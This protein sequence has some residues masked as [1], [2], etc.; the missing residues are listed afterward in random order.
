MSPM[1]SG[2]LT[3]F[4]S[5]VHRVF[6]FSTSPSALFLAPPLSGPVVMLVDRSDQCPK[7][8]PGG[9]VRPDLTHLFREAQWIP[10]SSLLKV[11]FSRPCSWDTFC[12]A[13]TDRRV[14]CCT[15]FLGIS[16]GR[17]LLKSAVSHI[18]ELFHGLV[19]Q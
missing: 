7:H 19:V 10:F 12:T 5:V 1:A 18:R 2:W 4:S 13:Q 15:F 8:P 3:S 16:Y 6:T 11:G 14:S 9:Q 17:A